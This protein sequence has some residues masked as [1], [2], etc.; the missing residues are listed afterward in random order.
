MNTRTS[1][2]CYVERVNRRHCGIIHVIK[3]DR[4]LQM[5][6]RLISSSY[7]FLK[8]CDYS[9]PLFTNILALGTKLIDPMRGVQQ[10]IAYLFNLFRMD[11]CEVKYLL[12]EKLVIINSSVANFSSIFKYLPESK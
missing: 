3:D 2:I 9:H 8:L 4:L 5:F 6:C 11:L 7:L 1:N 12:R 10:K